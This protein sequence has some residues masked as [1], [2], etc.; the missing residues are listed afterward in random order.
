MPA[1][2]RCKNSRLVRGFGLM[3]SAS[4]MSLILA[5]EAQAACSAS[6]AQPLNSITTNNSQVDC[7]GVTSG[8]AIAAN[9]D[10]VLVSV[11]LFGTQLNNSTVSVN[12]TNNT[13]EVRQS[14]STTNTSFTATGPQ[15]QV[16]F[17]DTINSFVTV[18]VSGAD[19][20][21]RINAGAITSA[22]QGS[23]TLSG[24][25]A[26]TSTFG[27]EGQLYGVTIA[28]SAYLVTGG[29][30]NQSFELRNGS[31]FS[32]QADG[33]AIDGGAGDDVFLIEDGA[34]IG[35]GTSNNIVFNGGADNDTMAILG[36]GTSN[37]NSINIEMLNLDPGSGGYRMLTGSHGGV[38]QFN[39]ASGTVNV[40]NLAALGQAGGNVGVA[41]GATLE[42]NQNSTST[43][44]QNLSGA[45]TIR[46]M[47]G[48]FTLNGNS[49]GFSG[50]YV[51]DGNRTI[52]GNSNALG[53]AD[54]INNS[55][56][57]FGDFTVANDISGT[58]L[59]SHGGPGVGTLGGNNTFTGDLGIL[60]GGIRLTSVNSAGTGNTIRGINPGIF[61]LELDIAADGTLANNIGSGIALTKSGAG[62]VTLT[63]TNTY[64][65][66]TTIN[67]GAI[68]VDNFARLGTGAVVANAG[69]SLILDYNG[70]GQLLQTTPFMSGAGSFI[71]E[72]SGDVVMNQ[73][74]TYTGGTTIRAGRIGL[75]NGDALGTGNIQVDAGATL[76]I[77]GITLANSVSG[78]GAIVKTANN[79]ATLSGDNSAFTGLF[80]VQD[81][82]VELTDG[83]AA[84]SGDL[85]IAGGSF[86]FVNSAV[87][88]TTI[89]A[90]ISGA[91]DLENFSN[92]RLT[93]T[94][95]NTLS[96]VVFVSNGTLQVEGSQNIGTANINVVSA[97]AR[98]DLNTAGSTVLSN[99]V[100]GNGGV[101]KTG[102]GT[103][104]LTGTN[105]YSGGTDI[106]QGALRVTDVSFLGTGAITVQQG[107]ALDLAI[108]GQ[109]SLNQAV[110]GAGILRKSD[111]GD[112]TLLSNGLTGGVDVVGGRVIVNTAGAIGGGPVSLAADTQLVFDN[113]ATE[114][115][116]TPIS[117]AGALTKEGAGLLVIN[118]ANS[119]TGGTVINAGRLGLNDGMG[120][121]TGPVIVMQNAILGIGGVTLAND[122]SGA[123]QVIKTANNTGALT[124]NNSFSGGLDIQQGS[125]VV[126]SPTALGTG[127]VNLSGAGTFLILDYNGSGNAALANAISGQGALVKDGS[128]TVVINAGGNSYTGGT[129]INAGRL[130]L[131]FGDGLGT[132]GVTINS[133][134]ELGIGNIAL[135][136][137]LTGTGRVVKTASGTGTLSGANTFS[138][139]IDIQG[140][141]L[142]VASTGSLGNGAI[143]TASG[144]ALTLGN[145]ANQTLSN[146]LT[147]AG[148]LVKSG[149]GDLTVTANALTG[150]T[151]ISAGRL[152]AT[153]GATGIGSGAV[154]VSSGAELV[155]TAPAN[156]TF[157]NAISGAGTLRKL[158][159]GQLL[160]GNPFTI[161]ALA[162]DAGSVRLNATLTG[163][164][165]V[166]TGARMDGT[167]RVIGNLTN[168]GTIAPGNS[169]GTL[170]VQGNY[171]HNAG[172]VLEIEF[173]GA[174]GIDLL[175]VTGTAT[176]NG[177]TLR[178]ISTTG[179]EGSGGT[180]LTA[181]GGVT[182][183]FATVETVGAALPLAVIYQPN[184]AIM[185][186][187]VLTARPST[188]NA[189]SFAAADS[190]LGFIDS[191]GV[192]DL[193][194]GQGNR[195]WMTGFGAWGNR[196]ASGT[197]LAYDHNSR[198][199]SGGVNFAAGDALTLGAAFGWAKGDITLG[200]NGGGGDQSS[201]LG[202]LHARYSGTGVTLGAGVLLGK[203]NQETLRNVSFN[204]FSA[205][206]S[207]E[208][209]SKVFG[210]YG[211]IGLP[212]GSTGGW[213][214][215]ANARGSYVHQTQDAYTESGNSPLRLAVGE[216]K[217]GTIEG[218]A[219]LTAK[220][221]LWDANRGGEELPGGL[222]LRIDLGGRYLGALGDRLIP[223]TFAA[224]NAGVVL[225][226]DTRNTLQGTGGVSLD[227]TTRG[228][229]TFSLGYLGEFGTTDRHSVRAGVSFAF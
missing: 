71:K 151:T 145:T 150:G 226:G 133:G 74:S 168:N 229:A 161:G 180:F 66:G 109:Q 215:S 32:V 108:A 120:L 26:T 10:N 9:A 56:L 11:R 196:T 181:G 213:A 228:G 207:G 160:F 70:A 208:T 64:A 204:G 6:P 86:V 72:G 59:V 212:L 63:G 19:S 209:D 153:G 17:V 47:D 191:I 142:F 82:G 95:N 12:G 93:L 110:S 18:N 34:F 89:A 111:L 166:A 85:A 28:G 114:V 90:D 223:V 170:N 113:A 4:L 75:N 193:R 68:R 201:V 218:Q 54:V 146:A 96:G 60:S 224:S 57:Q 164:A 155:Y 7:S 102:T 36:S 162:V 205:S 44:G 65:G 67:A 157:S 122:I 76:G 79:Q 197:T 115:S 203:V 147:G 143:S 39:V 22:N 220:T 165:S 40:T 8:A 179:A 104:L 137:S 38:N 33:R 52:L 31:T 100:A 91:G 163:N 159:A 21:F 3:A 87:G 51:I 169:I 125:V 154:A 200:S 117:G 101:V 132:G 185:A 176:L 148:A 144:T 123:G 178:F 83:R 15:A 73:S 222:D 94:G 48:A 135:A 211:E 134:A 81:G 130:G 199:L 25:A 217:T 41:A 138:G 80:D 97:A 55:L 184:S 174:G 219:R 37:Y 14:A 195:V 129:A 98:L 119:F 46:Q 61:G 177:G 227:Y 202:S 2:R 112:L 173:D 24:P 131:N 121:G 84:G 128:G 116:N 99:N 187:S 140:G 103:V 5:G 136:N 88:D 62:T 210:V 216:L 49:A 206:V 172:S 77:G 30:G 190:A 183:T 27:L 16:N 78:S 45:G 118:N 171:V 58:G 35:G 124:G 106:Q 175:A 50:T 189:Q 127:G 105:S 186:P 188:F 221:R 214:F 194:H 158:G 167:G 1:V 152:L 192:A 156:S 23:I 182:G 126:N 225:Q 13:I 69:G 141:N 149:S 139:G 107:A 29:T 53:T 43:I 198:G 20:A 92:T 42:L